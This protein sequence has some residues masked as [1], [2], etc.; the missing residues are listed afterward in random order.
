MCHG[1]VIMEIMRILGFTDFYAWQVTNGSWVRL[2]FKYDGELIDEMPLVG[3]K[4]AGG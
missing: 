1:G 2:R 4:S 3:G